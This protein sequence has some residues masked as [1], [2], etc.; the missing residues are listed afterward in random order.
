M[1]CFVERGLRCS[2]ARTRTSHLFVWDLLLGW[3]RAKRCATYQAG[4]TGVAHE[5]DVG[6][7]GSQNSPGSPR[8]N[9]AIA[10]MRVLFPFLIPLHKDFFASEMIAS[11]PSIISLP[12]CMRC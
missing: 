7:R 11:A 12:S 8:H 10:R 5:G 1:L 3:D 2:G 4:N 6:A 9:P